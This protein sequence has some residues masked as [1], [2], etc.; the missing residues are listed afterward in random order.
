MSKQKKYLVTLEA[1]SG[2]ASLNNIGVVEAE[3]VE[4]AT[5]K[6]LKLFKIKDHFTFM[7]SI[8]VQELNSLKPGWTFYV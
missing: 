3:T 1:T 4:E 5:M 7:R 2:L 6:A 8:M